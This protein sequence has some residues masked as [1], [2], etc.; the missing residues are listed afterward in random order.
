MDQS[1]D[2]AVVGAGTADVAEEP[3]ASKRPASPSA[4]TRF[5]MTVSPP[6]LFFD[7][8]MGFIVSIWKGDAR[9]YE[10]LTN[11]WEFQMHG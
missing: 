9:E 8:A 10:A 1:C 6:P 4:M 3:A 11:F 2:V 5:C 7:N